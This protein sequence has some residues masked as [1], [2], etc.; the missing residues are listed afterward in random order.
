MHYVNTET[1]ANNKFELCI[2]YH[3]CP[4]RIPLVLISH[5]CHVRAMSLMADQDALWSGKIQVALI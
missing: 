1:A 4:Q 3:G 5:M 2:M